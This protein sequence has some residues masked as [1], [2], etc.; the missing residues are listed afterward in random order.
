MEVEGGRFV[1]CSVGTED[2][3]AGGRA[4]TLTEQLLADKSCD[5]STRETLR[6]KPPSEVASCPCRGSEISGCEHAP[7]LPLSLPSVVCCSS[8]R[9]PGRLDS[10]P[11]DNGSGSKVRNYWPFQV[12]KHHNDNVSQRPDHPILRWGVK[13]DWDPFPSGFEDLL[14]DKTL[15]HPRENVPPNNVPNNLPKELPLPLLSGGSQVMAN[16]G[17]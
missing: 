3:P 13:H 1:G 11:S 8:S 16:Y 5:R 17:S 9:L 12:Q 4:H 15:K 10:L 2:K 14:Q 7:G 6:P